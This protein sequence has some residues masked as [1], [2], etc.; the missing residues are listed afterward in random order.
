MKP[1]T[2]LLIVTL[3]LTGCVTKRDRLTPSF[4]EAKRTDTVWVDYHSIEL[5]STPILIVSLKDSVNEWDVDVDEPKTWR[6]SYIDETFVSEYQYWDTYIN[7]RFFNHIVNLRTAESL[8]PMTTVT[9]AES[10]K[11]SITPKKV[12]EINRRVNAKLVIVLRDANFHLNSLHTSIVY[13][14]TV[15]DLYWFDEGCVTDQRTIVQ[16]SAYWMGYNRKPPLESVLAC[17]LKVSDDF[18]SLFRQKESKKRK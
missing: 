13:Y 11:E 6:M 1:T 7:G 15:W 12:E 14:R 5:D 4:Y 8:K 2:F 16:K 18:I 3:L 17:A 10:E 9:L